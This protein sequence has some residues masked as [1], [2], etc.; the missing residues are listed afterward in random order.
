MCMLNDEIVI[1]NCIF[2]IKLCCY[3]NLLKFVLLGKNNVGMFKLVVSFNWLERLVKYV[4]VK[5]L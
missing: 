1:I 5:M 2:I 3:C 4:F